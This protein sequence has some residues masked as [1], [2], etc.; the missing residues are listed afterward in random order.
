MGARY[1]ALAL[2]D[3]TLARNV[4]PSAAADLAAWHEAGQLRAIRTRDEVVGLL[5]VAPGSIVWID[6]D[7]VNEEVIAVDHRGHGYAALAQA[8]WAAHVATD[9]TRLLIGTI[10]RLNA[11]SR[12]TAEAAGRRSVLDVVFVAL[13]DVAR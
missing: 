3:P 13:G 9:Q 4:F 2:D 10:D 5:A 11:A 1:R 6:G 8:A 12:K 7:E